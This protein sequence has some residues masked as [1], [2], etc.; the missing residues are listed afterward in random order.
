MQKLASV[1][2]FGSSEICSDARTTKNLINIKDKTVLSRDNDYHFH[3]DLALYVHKF[4]ENS[5]RRR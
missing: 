5:V 4:K 3:T 2:L 1:H